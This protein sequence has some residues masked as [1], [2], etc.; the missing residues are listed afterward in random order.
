M[1]WVAV[2]KAGN[3]VNE[4]RRNRRYTA[5]FG[6]FYLGKWVRLVLGAPYC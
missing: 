3:E 1:L 5:K 4:K 6:G 2:Q